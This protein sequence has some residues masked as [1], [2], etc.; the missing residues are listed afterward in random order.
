MANQKSKYS[1]LISGLLLGVGIVNLFQIFSY[2][3]KLF[4][5]IY[6][7]L[8][9]LL[10]LSCLFKWEKFPLWLKWAFSFVALNDLI[11]ILLSVIN[12]IFFSD[13]SGKLMLSPDNPISYQILMKIISCHYQLVTWPSYLYIDLMDKIGRSGTSHLSWSVR[14][15]LVIV[16]VGSLGAVIS[17]ILG[18][19]RKK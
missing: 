17:I 2:D 7:F 14:W 12:Q 1:L 4:S 6:F 5:I 9:L 8:Y 3:R 16:W 19:G 10:G 15:A 11:M 13:L 18:W